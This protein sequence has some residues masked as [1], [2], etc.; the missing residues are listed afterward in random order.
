[1]ADSTGLGDIL[2]GAAGAPVNRPALNAYIT[3]GQAQAGLRSAQT[4]EALVNA[5]RGRDEA[6]AASQLEAAL[7]GIMKPADA[8]VAATVMRA[9]F[10]TSAQALD[11]LK[12]NQENQNRA[13]LSDPTQLGTP[14]QTAAAQGVQGKLEPFT[15]VPSA[16]AINPGQP[17]PDVQVSPVAQ[18]KMSL[19]DAQ[20]FLAHMKA[21]N[22]GAFQANNF[23][24]E[25]VMALHDYIVENPNAAP[26]GRALMTRGCSSVASSPT[27]NPSQPR[28][29]TT[30]ADGKPQPA[31]VPGAAPAATANPDTAAAVHVEGGRIKPAPGVSLAEQAAIRKDYASSKGAGGRMSSLNTMSLHSM[32]FDQI[33]DQIGNG[34]FKPTNTINVLWQRLFGEPAPSNLNIAGAFLGREAVR[35]TI[36]SG[37]GTGEER[38]LK[39]AQASNSPAVL[40]GAASTLRS[41]AGS[42][43]HSLIRA[44]ARGGVDATQ[45]LD[46][47]VMQAYGMQHKGGPGGAGPTLSHEPIPVGGAPEDPL[48]LLGK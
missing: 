44:A 36:N 42:Q 31:A 3:A 22:P 27:E 21:T 48:G 4:E 46:P 41:L 38:E 47:E 24:P 37:A 6:D 7:G 40:H 39:E 25:Q 26:T 12:T 15:Q 32:L 9:H 16:Y 45:Y 30:G 34:Q 23:T 1:M 10:G 43:L 33:A 11:A 28:P 5:Q 20:G 35:A 29:A 18:S 13:V 2:A 8:K 17:K 19:E 14:A